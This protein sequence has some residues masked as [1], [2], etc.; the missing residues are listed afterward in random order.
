MQLVKQKNKTHVLEKV[1]APY[2]EGKSHSL[3]IKGQ[4][5]TGKTTLA[6]E[7]LDMLKQNGLTNMGFYV[8]TRT[9]F[10][11]LC[12]QYPWAKRFMHSENIMSFLNSNS[13]SSGSSAVIDARMG[14]ADGLQDL[15]INALTTNKNSLIILDSW[16]SLAKEFDSNKRIKMEKSIGTI[17][18]TQNGCVIFISEEPAESTVDY[19]VDGVVTLD[20]KKSDA[21][22]MRTMSIDKMRATEIDKSQMVYTLYDSHFNILNSSAQHKHLNEK[23]LFDPI[24]T[25]PGYISSGNSILDDILDGGFESGSVVFLELDQSLSDVIPTTIL[26]NLISNTIRSNGSA[27]VVA[28]PD[29]PSTNITKFVDGYCSDSELKNLHILSY[30]S[31]SSPLTMDPQKNY[32]IFNNKYAQLKKNAFPT[33]ISI[34]YGKTI[35]GTTNPKKTNQFLMNQMR[36]IRKNNDVCMIT[37]TTQQTDSSFCKSICD[38]H[39]N[40][41]LKHGSVLLQTLRPFSGTFGMSLSVENNYP[42]YELIKLV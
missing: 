35:Q 3:L 15:V 10:N 31:D 16:D 7:L 4:P 13:Y 34:D 18:E 37:S 8:S 25:R 30:D 17:S 12:L 32:D 2:F 6:L 21:V 28:P 11:S 33:V 20:R 24:I 27:L 36:Q 39:M 40:L 26:S 38:V 19:L 5:G 29:K 14:T 22:T 42:Q 9:S 23:K 41:S 1:F